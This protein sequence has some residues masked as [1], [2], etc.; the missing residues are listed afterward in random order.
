M[1]TDTIDYYPICRAVAR[2]AEATFDNSVVVENGHGLWLVAVVIADA[3]SVARSLSHA[4]RQFGVWLAD[5]GV[6]SGALDVVHDT[7]GGSDDSVH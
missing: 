4:F 1:P 2:A 7:I 5:H 6:L 3:L